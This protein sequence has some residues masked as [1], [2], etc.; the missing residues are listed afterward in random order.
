MVSEDAGGL[1]CSSCDHAEEAHS[2]TTSSFVQHRSPIVIET[3][4][5]NN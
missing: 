1:G 3:A 2:A 5:R 4:L